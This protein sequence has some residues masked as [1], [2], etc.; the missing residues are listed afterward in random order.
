MF[1]NVPE[2]EDLT[3]CS[4]EEIQLREENKYLPHLEIVIFKK[5]RTGTFNNIYVDMGRGGCRRQNF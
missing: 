5:H 2:L 1:I 4:E 3:E